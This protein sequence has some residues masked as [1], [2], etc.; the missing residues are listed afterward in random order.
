MKQSSNGKFNFMFH[1][2]VINLK[3]KI[4]IYLETRQSKALFEEIYKM[5]YV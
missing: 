1:T 5:I 2:K 3:Y 4:Y